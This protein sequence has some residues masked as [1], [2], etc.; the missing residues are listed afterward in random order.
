[1]LL[2]TTARTVGR[3]QPGKAICPRK[4]DYTAAPILS[5]YTDCRANKGKSCSVVR[6]CSWDG[7]REGRLL[8]INRFT[9]DAGRTCFNRY[10]EQVIWTT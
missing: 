9:A 10:A 5:C 7:D 2:D 4:H 8:L 1:M 6:S 3:L